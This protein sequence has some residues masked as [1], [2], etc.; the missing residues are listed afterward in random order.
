M[1]SD[2]E[3]EMYE[4]ESRCATPQLRSSVH[5][6]HID[7][8][9]ASPL[10]LTTAGPQPQPILPA[11]ATVVQ[12]T[13]PEPAAPADINQPSTSALPQ[14]ILSILGEAK[15]LEQPLGESIPTELSERWG[16]ILVDGLAKDQKELLVGKMPVPS[17]FLLAQAPK[18]N[19]E[20]AAV[21]H[22]TAKNRDKRLEV[23]QNQ[24]GVGI[25]GLANLTKDLI[26]GDLIK[27]E[28]IT[29]MSEITQ[30]L[31]DLHYEGSV[32]RKK[33]LLPLLDKKFWS[34][35]QGVKRDHYLFGE[36]L[37]ESI[38]N[39]K[40]IAKSGQ[41][42]KRPSLTQPPFQQRKQQP[43]SGNYRAPPR[44]QPA[45]LA[46]AAPGRYHEQQP[47][48]AAAR[49]TQHTQRRGRPYSTHKYN[50]KRRRY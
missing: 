18:L 27:L 31:L 45:K 3:L 30:V 22:D 5:V 39:T 36:K 50:E 47:T 8:D 20:V 26:K 15:K 38:K 46:P 1:F 35:I 6:P 28:I 16:K 14:E 19:Q 49:R 9:Q 11:A 21:L 37:G 4:S 42:L 7:D 34:T 33:L 24:L 23:A 10:P 48:T 41:D 17:N 40:E 2:A 29:R 32:N 25:A 44:H 13:R 12:S 43:L